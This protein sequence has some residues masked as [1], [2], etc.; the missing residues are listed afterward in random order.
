VRSRRRE[1][2]FRRVVLADPPQPNE[3]AQR[4]EQIA[5]SVRGIKGFQIRGRK[6]LALVVLR[7]HAEQIGNRRIELSVE[8]VSVRKVALIRLERGIF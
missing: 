3:E 6:I 1:R 2:V 8:H 7:L 4:L 5:I